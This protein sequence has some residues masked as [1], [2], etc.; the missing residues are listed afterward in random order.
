MPGMNFVSAHHC[1]ARSNALSLLE[2]TLAKSPADVVRD[3][4]ESLAK[5]ATYK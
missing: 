2:M 5:R 4:R 3:V 1:R